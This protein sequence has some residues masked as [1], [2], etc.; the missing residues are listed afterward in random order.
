MKTNKKQYHKRPIIRVTGDHI[1]LL[2]IG[3][4]ILG[5]VIDAGILF[6]IW[7]LK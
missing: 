6:S 3:L 2:T 5:L 7:M 1:D 4:G